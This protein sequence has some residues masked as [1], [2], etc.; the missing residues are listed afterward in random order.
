M[1]RKHPLADAADMLAYMMRGDRSEFIESLTATPD[2]GDDVN[3][4]ETDPAALLRALAKIVDPDN[5]RYIIAI[6]LEGRFNE[7]CKLTI[8]EHVK[9]GQL[10]EFQE[11]VSHYKLVPIEPQTGETHGS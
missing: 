2:K 6:K 10:M 11:A 8:E 1:S 4:I 7:F 3:P 9:I 5:K